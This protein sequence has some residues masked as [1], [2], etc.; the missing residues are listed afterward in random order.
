MKAVRIH[1]YGGPE[2]LVYE[3]AP[4]PEPGRAELLV[5]VHA[6]GINPVDWKT[7]E[8]HLKALLR[9]R[10]PLILGWDFS[11]VVEE[12]GPAVTDFKPGDEVYARPDIGRDGAYADYI[13][14]KAKEVALKPKILDHVHAAAVPLAAL[15]AWQS[16][17]EAARLKSGQRVLIHAAAGGVGHF[18]VQLAKWKGAHVIG[19]AS[20]R[21]AE[22]VRSLGA[23]EIIDYTTTRFEDVVRDVD[24]VFDTVGGEVQQ[25]SFKVVKKGGVLVSVL[26]PFSRLKA[27]FRGVRAHFVFVQPNAKQLAEL[28]N[29]I[30]NGKL[31]PAVETVLPLAEAR[32]AHALS[33]RGHTRGKLVLQVRESTED[34]RGVSARKGEARYGLRSTEKVPDVGRIVRIRSSSR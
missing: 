12:V 30:D 13:A 11:G 15:T 10:L 26:E 34:S 17:F 14:V 28:A 9:Y 27:A 16:L 25:R 32:Q 2:A 31:K 8:G 22:F 5:R 19:T 21:N 33:Q 1:T 7:R 24:V 23:E 3:D 29:L 20:G 4:Q 6:A 18:A